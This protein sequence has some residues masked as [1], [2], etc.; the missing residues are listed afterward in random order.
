[1]SALITLLDVNVLIAICDGHHVDHIRASEWFAQNAERGWATCPFVQNG[2]IRIMSQTAYP[3]ARPIGQVIRQVRTIC[4]SRHHHFWANDLSILDASKITH[5][6][7]LGN[8]QITDVYLL[9]LAVQNAGRFL[10]IDGKIP[11]QA[12]NG[13]KK[14]NLINLV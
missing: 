9:A 12:V 10:T 8:K 11:L 14:E 13:A 5:Q 4:E 2:V 1:M 6:H 3:N 7:L